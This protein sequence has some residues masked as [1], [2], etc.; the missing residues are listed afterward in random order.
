MANVSTDDIAGYGAYLKAQ[1]V[2]D[3]DIQG[4]TKYLA[5]QHDVDH[6]SESNKSWLDMEIPGG[7]PRG[8]IKGA[9]G[10][11]PTAGMVAGGIVGLPEGGVGAIPGAALGGAAGAALKNIGEKYIL[12]EDKTRSDVYGDPVVSGI[13][14]AGSEMA[15]RL[16]GQGVNAAANS[17][18]G[19]YVIGKAGKVASTVGSAFSGIPQKELETYAGN[20]DEINALAK[21]AKYSSQE[22]ADNLRSN[23]NS[24][25]QETKQGLNNQI[26]QAFKSRAGETVDAQP[27]LDQLSAAKSQINSKLRPE[28]I[29]Q[30]DEMINQV[31]AVTKEGQIDLKDAHDLKELLQEQASGSYSKNGQIFQTGT[32]AQKAAKTGAAVTR[33]LVNDAAPEIAHANDTLSQLHDV[34]D[35]MNRS[36]LA[37]GKTGASLYSAGSGANEANEAAL[38]E[39]GNITGKN[40]LGDAQK[41]AAAKTFGKAPVLPVDATGKTATRMGVAGASGYLLGG[42]PGAIITEGLSSPLGIKAAIN[43]GNVTGKIARSTMQNAPSLVGNALQA[44]VR[45][46]SSSP[47]D[48]PGNAPVISPVQNQT[49]PMASPAPAAPQKPFTPPPS[50]ISKGPSKWAND[51]FQKLKSHVNDEDREFLE[52][53]KGALML[54]PKTKNL[55]ITA[56]NYSSGSKPLDQI[57][58]HLKD[59]MGKK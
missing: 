55:L 11:L 24:Q 33:S 18:A 47:V 43:A 48:E 39:L 52:K 12:G 37:E 38:K 35:V 36:M 14:G 7:T 21:E 9:L 25:V 13:E 16:I 26:S 20:T 42:V 28:E 17:K 57:V 44:G 29:Q 59:R 23:I 53:N 50:E 10:A 49:Q 41:I 27:I 46:Y 45:S 22:M 56:S 15:G 3:S 2:P 34:E 19:K 40:F 30:V 31:K 8:Y 54:D 58:Q 32:K 6:P 5:D 1:G 51:G 4:Y